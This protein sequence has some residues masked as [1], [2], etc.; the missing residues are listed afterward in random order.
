MKKLNMS[1]KFSFQGVAK[2]Q[3]EVERFAH[4]DQLVD[5]K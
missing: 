5:A 3:K 1:I 2:R 4:P